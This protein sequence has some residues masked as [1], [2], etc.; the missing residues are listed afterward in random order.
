LTEYY[1]IDTNQLSNSGENLTLSDA[2]GG[3]IKQFSYSD[4]APWPTAADGAGRSLVLIAPALNPDHNLAINWRASTALL[5]TPGNSDA[6]PPPSNPNGDDDGNGV[7]NLV[8]YFF[9]SHGG[10]R[11]LTPFPGGQAGV[12]DLEYTRAANSD[13]L[14]AV[15]TSTTLLG[16]VPAPSELIGRTVHPDGTETLRLRVTPPE[17][18]SLRQFVRLHISTR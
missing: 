6:L 3:I 5:G 7:P 18:T 15:Q 14:A 1:Q 2:A 9:G 12:F 8:Q 17:P 16:W 13:A 4:T 11:Q 10:L